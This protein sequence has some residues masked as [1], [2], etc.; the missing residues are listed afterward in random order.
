MGNAFGRPSVEPAEDAIWI[1][2][3]GNSKKPMLEIDRLFSTP[4]ISAGTTLKVRFGRSPRSNQRRRSDARH[5]EWSGIDQKDK[6]RLKSL[7]GKAQQPINGQPF[8]TRIID[9]LDDRGKG[10]TAPGIDRCPSGGT[11]VPPCGIIAEVR[12]AP[13]CSTTRPAAPGPCTPPAQPSRRTDDA[14]DCT[15]PSHPMTMRRASQAV[16]VVAGS[17]SSDRGPWMIARRRCFTLGQGLVLM[18]HL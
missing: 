14:L 17:P 7:R 2:H 4:H 1:G 18:T 16:P 9:A 3:V 13:S 5:A 15:S 10:V 11:H 6:T 8:K 12:P